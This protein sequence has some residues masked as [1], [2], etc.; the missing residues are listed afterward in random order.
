MCQQSGKELLKRELA[1]S[2]YLE[3]LFGKSSA[4]HENL[5]TKGYID[6]SF[7]YD[8]TQEQGFGF[9]LIGGD[10]TKPD[11]LVDQLQEILLQSKS[12]SGLE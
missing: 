7:S 11:E 1:T 2:L 4:I 3:M 8:Y 5:Y 9:A 6:Q 12:G 10:T